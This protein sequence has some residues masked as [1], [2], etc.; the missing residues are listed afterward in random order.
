MLCPLRE[1]H[2]KLCDH[3]F[4]TKQTPEL[5]K[6]TRGLSLRPII[7]SAM[8]PAVSLS[9]FLSGAHTLNCLAG[10]IQLKLAYTGWLSH[11]EF[12]LVYVEL[13]MHFVIGIQAVFIRS[14]HVKVMF[15]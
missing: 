4:V 10:T 8:A 7:Q 2:Y 9:L 5:R 13:I 11:C 14:R 3:E 15:C 6:S 1:M 12:I